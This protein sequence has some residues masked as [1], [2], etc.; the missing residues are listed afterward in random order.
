MNTLLKRTISGT[1]YAAALVGCV[2]WN[3]FSFLAIMLFFLVCM[4]TEFMKM[5]MGNEYKRSQ[6][7]TIVTGVAFFASVWS[8]RSFPWIKAEFCFLALI[9]LF[10]VMITSLYVKDKGD[11][12]KFANVYTA[13]VYVVLPLT[14]N[15]FLVMDQFGTYNGWLLICFFAIISSSDVGAYIFGMALGQ[16]FGKKLFP[17]ISPKK[18][19]IGF[20]GGMAVMVGVSLI[21]Y[22]TG[23]WEFCGL[24][25]FTWYHAMIM[26]ILMDIAGVYGD[27]FESQWKRHYEVKD[28]GNIIPGHGGILDRLDSSIFAIPVGVLYLSLFKLFEV[29][30]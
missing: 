29:V 30:M 5:T 2:L 21:F 4:M 6:L 13:L 23:L 25:M 9:P 15:N 10:A 16:K 17:S 11:F 26:A 22:F 28:S 24:K 12:G 14:I 8:V 18:S 1:V 19:W 20:W 3:K 7:L 27:L